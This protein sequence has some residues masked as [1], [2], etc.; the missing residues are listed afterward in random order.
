[1][2]YHYHYISDCH[3]YCYC[4]HV[5]VIAVRL[6]SSDSDVLRSNTSDYSN[7]AA[8][9]NY[10]NALDDEPYIAAEI[11][12]SNYPMTFALGD[13]ELTMVY[14]DFPELDFN[15]PLMEGRSYNYFVR[16]F[17]PRPPVNNIVIYI[18]TVYT[19]LL[20]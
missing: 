4:S 13:N 18:P 20:L 3:E 7:R 17:S 6:S 5:W 1:M 12:A 9:K 8:F 2:L 16:F 14:S 15:G 10:S 19:S 11:D